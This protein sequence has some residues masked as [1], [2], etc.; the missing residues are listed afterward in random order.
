VPGLQGTYEPLP[1]AR[2]WITASAAAA[3]MIALLVLR[4]ILEA[5][6]GPAY[7]LV[8]RVLIVIGAGACGV[9]AIRQ[10]MSAAFAGVEKRQSAITWRN[11]LSWTLYI[12]LALLLTPAVGPNL[13]A[14]AF[15]GAVL[16]VVLATLSQSSL[17]NFFA[18]LVLL[19]ARPYRVGESVYLRS[20]AYGGA[21]YVGLVVDVG[22]FYTT[23]SSQGQLV[24]IPNSAVISSVLITRYSPVRADVGLDL[25]ASVSLREV[26]DTVRGQLS[27][28]ADARVMV[29]PVRYTAAGEERRIEARL[30]VR[31]DHRIEAGELFRAV[32]MALVK[33]SVTAAEVIK[34]PVGVGADHGILERGRQER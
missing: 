27:L 17:N 20:G 15:G 7:G 14:F 21:E 10:A 24:R 12:V 9:L 5:T 34:T 1:R 33:H 3:A 8:A 18:G 2:R 30:V 13:T 11:L 16:T 32:D 31:T 4:P 23:L 22:A 28:P 6:I 19:L 29:E 25:P 26:E